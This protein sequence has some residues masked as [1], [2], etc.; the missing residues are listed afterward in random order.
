MRY[1]DNYRY[2]TI[3]DNNRLKSS[4]RCCNC[5]KCCNHCRCCS[6][7]CNMNNNYNNTY[8]ADQKKKVFSNTLPAISYS[9]DDSS[10]DDLLKAINESLIEYDLHLR[11]NKETNNRLC[12]PE[13]KSISTRDHNPIDTY[14]KS[15]LNNAN[16]NN[17]VNTN[18]TTT[19]NNEINLYESI[20]SYSDILFNNA[21]CEN[22]HYDFIVGRGHNEPKDYI[23]LP[24][25]PAFAKRNV[26]FIDSNPRVNA[27][28]QQSIQD[29]DFSHFGICKEQKQNQYQ[30][31]NQ[32]FNES[33]NINFIFDWS[34]FYCGAMHNLV[35]I[36]NNLG[37]KCRIFIPLDR[38]HDTIPNDIMQSLENDMFEIVIKDG[39]YPLF[40]WN[41]EEY[42]YLE[43]DQK[44]QSNKLKLVSDYV[45]PDRYILIHAN[46]IK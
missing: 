46:P 22:E 33:I 45:N 44:S 4:N 24:I 21:F 29:I 31:Q 16:I 10:H 7:K 41:K 15:L 34:S 6:C 40:D 2:Q 18:S 5:H 8:S 1:T 38:P 3:M 17:N 30:Y 9:N 43:E 20:N 35:N 36:M 32:D 27:D 28:I 23:N 42:V 14:I 26:V 11:S 39:L 25:N 12:Y 13:M 19:I 37:R